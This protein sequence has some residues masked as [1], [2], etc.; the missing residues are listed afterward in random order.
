M[1]LIE[2]W[3]NLLCRFS[4]SCVSTRARSKNGKKDRLEQEEGVSVVAAV[5]QPRDDLTGA[6]PVVYDIPFYL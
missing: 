4:K 3:I 6:A 5:A 2:T 1:S